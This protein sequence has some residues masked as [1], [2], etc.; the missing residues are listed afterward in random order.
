MQVVNFRVG[1]FVLAVAATLLTISRAR[2]TAL[3]PAAAI[4][5]SAFQ[6]FE[7]EKET[8]LE[9]GL[10]AIS[11]SPDWS[12]PARGPTRF[13][14]S[15]WTR[16]DEGSGVEMFSRKPARAAAAEEKR[17]VM[18]DGDSLSSAGRYALFTGSS[19]REESAAVM[20]D[21]VGWA[22]YTQCEDRGAGRV[23]ATVT[24][25]I[26]GKMKSD[27]VE[28]DEKDFAGLEKSETRAI[29]LI[30]AM[31]GSEHQLDNVV[32]YGNR[33]GLKDPAQTTKGR[34]MRAADYPEFPKELRS[35]CSKMASATPTLDPSARKPA[36]QR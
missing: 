25:E 1:P 24:P 3:L 33:M 23:C 19:A 11:D 12:V 14:R 2:A 13:S 34:L 5:G 9:P 32:R 21:D 22:S 20:A 4:N 35:A 36:A 17:V 27:Q 10:A 16:E 28:L 26:C 30:L 31:R 8:R 6:E 7:R 18:R 29:A 15:K